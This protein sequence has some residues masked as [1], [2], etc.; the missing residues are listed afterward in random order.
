LP[1][2]P[3]GTY[4][5]RMG[6]SAN[7]N[8]GM[9]Q[10]YLGRN[11]SIASMRTLDIP[12]DMRHVPSNQTTQSGGVT[13]YSPDVVTGWLP[14]LSTEDMGVESDANM[15]NLGWMRG[16]L[17]FMYGSTVA[18]GYAGDLRRII[19]KGSFEQ[20]EY[21]IR[22]KTV[23]PNNTS[24]EFHLDYIEFC[25]EYVYNNPIYVEDMY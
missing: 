17:C 2:V 14:Y 15:H 18:R 12:L 23:L 25:P 24:T 22:F 11:S 21:W 1:P 20:G 6:Y 8:R 4:E 10:F 16:P 13:T 5:L 9:V 19:T 3:D 7:G